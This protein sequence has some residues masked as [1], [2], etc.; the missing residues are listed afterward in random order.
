MENQYSTL[1]FLVFHIMGKDNVEQ[2]WFT[3][4]AI[5]SVNK[6]IDDADKI[7]QL[8]TIFRDRSIMWYMKYKDT[9]LARHA[10]SLV[11]IK[12]DILW[13]FQNLK[14]ES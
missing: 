9:T 14:S 4:E 13:E 3:Y 7:M 12:Q 2:H 8:H 1:R 5:W 6:V 11:K 10:R